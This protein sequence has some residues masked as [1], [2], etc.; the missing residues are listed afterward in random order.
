MPVVT[1]VQEQ[2]MIVLPKITLHYNGSD[3]FCGFP[4]LENEE[5]VH[6]RNKFVA[7]HGFGKFDV[8]YNGRKF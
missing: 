4:E 5:Q 1:E 2:N 6:C 8:G 7:D 3:M